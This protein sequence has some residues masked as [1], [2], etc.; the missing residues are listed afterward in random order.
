VSPS[1]AGTKHLQF[2]TGHGAVLRV[3]TVWPQPE[4]AVPQCSAGGCFDH[5]AIAIV[6]LNL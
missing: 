3:N 2:L 5:V 6:V 1:P 4:A